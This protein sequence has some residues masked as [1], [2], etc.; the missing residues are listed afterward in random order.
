MSRFTTTLAE[1]LDGAYR[2]RCTDVLSPVEYGVLNRLIA[3]SGRHI[4]F[5]PIDGAKS[6]GQECATRLT[7]NIGGVRTVVYFA[8]RD[9]TA[10]H[11]WYAFDDLLPAQRA[12]LWS[13]RVS[14][15]RC[16]FERL[17]AAPISVCAV[18]VEAVPAGW[19]CVSLRLGQ[20]EIPCWFEAADAARA[21][22]SARPHRRPVLPSLSL[23]PVVCALRLRAV[24]VSCDEY[25]ILAR[26]DV[27]LITRDAC[28]PIRGELTAPGFGYRYPMT[29]MREGILVIEK[30][31]IKLDEQ[32][33]AMEL[34]DCHVE[35]AVELATCRLT[36][37][38]LANLS[39]GQTLRLP[40]AADE[41]SVDI[42]LRSTRVA[43]GSLI[44]I[45]GLLGV[46]IDA[47]GIDTSA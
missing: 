46:R 25:R 41:M 17:F 23:L 22:A 21:L 35:L 16:A 18:V 26:G 3:M 12:E 13:L 40:K 8:G 11:G 36:L 6:T 7:L 9:A 14:R 42:R 20:I 24:R 44:E 1:D 31:E 29:F 34:D 28:A 15:L 10:R 37:G 45:N 39:A 33:V 19:S 38:E 4:G 30:N 43:R 5:R 32:D 27:M 2:F 47:I